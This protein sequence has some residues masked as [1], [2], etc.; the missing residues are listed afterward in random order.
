MNTASTAVFSEVP[1]PPVASNVMEL[2]SASARVVVREPVRGWLDGVKARF[3]ELVQMRSGW[4]GYQGAPVSFVN[5]NF[6]LRM[7][8]AVCGEN[9]P[10][11]QIV[12][13]PDGDLQIEWHTIGADIELHVRG[14]N[15]VHAWRLVNGAA[16]GQERVLSN[17]FT[18]VSAWINELAEPM[19][20][21]GAAA[22]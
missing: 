9:A 8:E 21:T 2:R 6:A 5:A 19:S 12:P 11:P 16:D 18:L 10:M 4:D 15:D 17:D 20:A 13:G 7:L 1:A 22:A 14:P 3:N